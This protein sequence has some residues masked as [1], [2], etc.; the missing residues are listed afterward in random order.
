MYKILNK[1]YKTWKSRFGIIK[2]LP[3]R[4]RYESHP[5]VKIGRFAVSK[6]HQ[7]NKVGTS[8][9]DYI[10]ALF[11]IKNKTGCKF[12]TI[13]AYKDATGFYM[14]NGF[15]FLTDDDMGDDHRQMYFDLFPLSKVLD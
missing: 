15:D 4:K 5:A 9:M 1:I 8:L 10:K 2:Q 7:K 13:D 12:I 3:R 11:I 6:A 14:K